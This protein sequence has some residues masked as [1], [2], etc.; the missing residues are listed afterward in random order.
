LEGFRQYATLPMEED[1]SLY[2]PK[3]IERQVKQNEY[4]DTL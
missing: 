1:Y 3:T 2:H 4:Y